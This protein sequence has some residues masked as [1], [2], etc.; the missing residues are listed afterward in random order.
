MCGR[1]DCLLCDSE[2]HICFG[3]TSL[4]R[5]D[6]KNYY[7][8]H[9]YRSLIALIKEQVTVRRHHKLAITLEALSAFKKSVREELDLIR[10]TE[11]KLGLQ[12]RRPWNS[13]DPETI[14][15]KEGEKTSE[16]LAKRRE[17][18]ARESAISDKRIAGMVDG[19]ESE[20]KV[21]ASEEDARKCEVL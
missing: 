12:D 13:A 19:S 11:A 2:M 16:I 3:D 1:Y 7:C 6:L 8:S 5:F 21:E 4:N 15:K 20:K 17:Q 18:L 9:C 14:I 10:K